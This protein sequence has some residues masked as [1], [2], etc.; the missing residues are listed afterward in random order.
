M[1]PCADFDMV[2]SLTGLGESWVHP[3]DFKQKSFAKVT[4]GQ[5]GF[6]ECTEVRRVGM[7]VGNRWRAGDAAATRANSADRSDEQA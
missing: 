5:G 7:A 6:Q 3:L 1:R 2:F 4:K